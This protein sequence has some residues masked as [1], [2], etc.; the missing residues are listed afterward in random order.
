MKKRAC[1]DMEEEKVTKAY[2]FIKNIIFGSSHLF[3]HDAGFLFLYDMAVT[4]KKSIKQITGVS[5]R[6][7]PLALSRSDYK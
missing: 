7:Y 6:L 3:L 1:C 5:R 4:G 2:L